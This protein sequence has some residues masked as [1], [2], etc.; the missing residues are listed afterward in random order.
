MVRILSLF[1]LVVNIA[2][3]SGKT[4]LYDS[5]NITPAVDKKKVDKINS[6]KTTWKAKISEK[7]VNAKMS[8][9][10]RLV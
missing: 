8:D 5:D 9:A 4:I 2:T 3:L 7:F 6:L 10:K 1:I